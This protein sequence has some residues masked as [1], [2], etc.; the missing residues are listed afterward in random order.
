MK[1]LQGFGF[2]TISR[3]LNESVI[4]D[5]ETTIR[6]AAIHANRVVLVIRADRHIPVNRAEVQA[7]IFAEMQA[8]LKELKENQLLQEKLKNVADERE[9]PY[10]LKTPKRCSK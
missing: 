5:Y 10:S 8:T 9:L 6:I 2:L 1:S 7:S 4:V 3:K